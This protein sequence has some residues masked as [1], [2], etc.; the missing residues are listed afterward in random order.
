MLALLYFKP[1]TR[2]DGLQFYSFLM[3]N[4][5]VTSYVGYRIVLNG[6]VRFFLL[7]RRAD[8]RMREGDSDEQF[9]EELQELLALHGKS[10]ERSNGQELPS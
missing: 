9:R 3:I 4:G 1:E 10:T 8:D 5:L 7:G 6:F 2:K